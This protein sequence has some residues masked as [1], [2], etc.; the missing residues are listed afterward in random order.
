VAQ[1]RMTLSSGRD[2]TL[3]E[4]LPLPVGDAISR[5]L[6]LVRDSARCEW[7]P[8]I[9]ELKKVDAKTFTTALEV[10]RLIFFNGLPWQR[11]CRWGI[12][13]GCHGTRYR[14]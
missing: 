13:S 6:V 4:I 12:S 10:I 5:G 7:Q 11:A 3:G 8:E 9:Q 14:Q 2:V 1:L